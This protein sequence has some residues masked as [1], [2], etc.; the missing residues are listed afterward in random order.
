MAATSLDGITGNVNNI[1]W[2]TFKWQTGTENYSASANNWNVITINTTV[3]NNIPSCSLSSNQIS[4]PSGKYIVTASK[5]LQRTHHSRIGIYDATNLEMMIQG[6]N[7]YCYPDTSYGYKNVMCEGI[8]TPTAT[9][10]YELRYYTRTNGYYGL[11]SGKWVN[12]VLAT[13]SFGKLME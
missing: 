3:E 8:L 2:S 5:L 4:L 11:G 9:T 10:V 13:L 1:R 12:G 6:I 7:T